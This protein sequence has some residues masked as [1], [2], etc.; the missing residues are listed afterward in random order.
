MAENVEDVYQGFTLLQVASIYASMDD[1]RKR[2]V[3]RRLEQSGALPV[4]RDTPSYTALTNL[5][6]GGGGGQLD[7]L[8]EAHSQ[9]VKICVEIKCRGAS[10]RHR[11]DACSTAWRCRFLSARDTLVDFHTGENDGGRTRRRHYR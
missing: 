7:Y 1:E 3:L 5:L 6:W 4:A 11:R 2:K 9:A 10:P 8:R